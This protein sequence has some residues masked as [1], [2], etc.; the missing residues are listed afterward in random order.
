MKVEMS[1]SNLTIQ[2]RSDIMILSKISDKKY[3]RGGFYEG[4]YKA[5]EFL[6]CDGFFCLRNSAGRARLC[7]SSIPESFEKNGECDQ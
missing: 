7:A 2:G 3:K 1:T 5:E 6:A 4:I